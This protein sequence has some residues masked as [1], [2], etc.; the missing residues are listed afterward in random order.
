MTAAHV[1]DFGPAYIRVT[2]PTAFEAFSEALNY[3]ASVYPSRSFS[4]ELF[5]TGAAEG[6]IVTGAGVIAKAA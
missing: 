1:S 4:F 3:V 6:A 5:L 2:A